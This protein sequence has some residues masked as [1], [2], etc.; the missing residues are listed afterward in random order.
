[1][2]FFCKTKCFYKARRWSPG[3]ILEAG[4]GEKVPAH[5]VRQ[6]PIP[7]EIP[8]DPETFSEIAGVGTVEIDDSKPM[9]LSQV[10]KGKKIK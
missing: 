1:M 4:S 2:K 5:F 10:G 7:Q 9:A 8:K 6:E 3:E